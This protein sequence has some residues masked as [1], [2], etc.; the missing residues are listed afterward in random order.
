MC[1]MSAHAAG[2]HTDAMLIID[3]VSP[4][5]FEPPPSIGVSAP[6]PE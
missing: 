1:G 4:H 2:R 3:G 6:E 5:R